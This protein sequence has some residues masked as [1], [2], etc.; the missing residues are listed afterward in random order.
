MVF[1]NKFK[2]IRL[3]IPTCIHCDVITLYVMTQI[4]LQRGRRHLYH[5]NHQEKEMLQNIRVC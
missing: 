4:H 2:G 5:H 3:N 1:N